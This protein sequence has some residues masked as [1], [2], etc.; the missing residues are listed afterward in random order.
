[1]TSQAAAAI[2]AAKN[3]KRWGQYATNR[4]LKNNGVSK[5]LFNIARQCEATI[6]RPFESRVT[7]YSSLNSLI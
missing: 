2:K 4:F 3:L 5:R 1:M 7:V 6:G